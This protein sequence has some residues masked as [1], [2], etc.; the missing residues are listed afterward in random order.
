MLYIQDKPDVKDAA[1]Q[2]QMNLSRTNAVLGEK[3]ED[4]K[5]PKQQDEQQGEQGEEVLCMVQEKGTLIYLCY[6]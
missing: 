6:N 1:V 4:Y 2:K 3:D 5:N